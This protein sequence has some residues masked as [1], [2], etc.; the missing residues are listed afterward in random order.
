MA[1][2]RAAGSGPRWYDAAVTYWD[3]QEAS[4][5][6]V[7]GGFEDLSGVDI[8]DSTRFLKKV[9]ARAAAGEWRPWQGRSARLARQGFAGAFCS[10]R[11]VLLHAQVLQQRQK[12]PGDGGAASSHLIAA[13]E[14]ARGSPRPTSKRAVL[15]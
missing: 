8:Q 9:R 6:G 1:A 14:A 2:S 11:T 15:G 10:Q 12:G 3:E 4:N 13:G 5:N 7:L